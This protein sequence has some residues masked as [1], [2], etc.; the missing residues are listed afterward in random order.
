MQRRFGKALL[1][2]GLF[3][4]LAGTATVAARSNGSSASSYNVGVVYSRTGPLS[5]YGGEYIEGLRYGLR[6][7]TKGTNKVNGKKI[8][9]TI[10]DDKTDAST[11]VNAAKD[12]IGKGYKIVDGQ[13]LVGRRDP[14]RAARRAEPG[15]LPL[16]PRGHRRSHRPEQV[17]VPKRP[18]D[19]A[20]HR[21]RQLLPEGRGEEGRRLRPGLG[22]RPRQLRGRQGDRRRQGPHRERDL[23]AAGS[24]TDFTPFAQQAKSANPDLLFVAW[25]GTSAAAMWKALDQQ[26]VFSGADVVTGLPERATW[27]SFGDQALKIHFLSHYVSSA[28]KNKVNDWL[29][30]QLRK[31]NQVPDLFAPDGF[32]AALMLVH[33]LKGGD[34]NVD[35]MINALEGYKFQGPK[36]WSAVRPQDHALLQPMFRLQLVKV[37]GKLRGKLLG[38]ATSFATAPPIAAFK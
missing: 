12:L 32:N 2:V 37:N 19:A 25:A 14:G 36:G 38:T 8:N 20:G 23:G 33:A 24:A 30:N 10:V 13:H 15:A 5:A 6:Y 21:D 35:K 28:P 7:A 9:L 17:H 16:R 31:R 4:L 26:N 27:S 18:A 3:T 1:V 34:Y 22:L 11:A 29:V